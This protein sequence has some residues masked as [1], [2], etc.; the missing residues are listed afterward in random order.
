MRAFA[1]DAYNAAVYLKRSAPQLHVGFL[2]AT[3]EDPLSRAMRDAFAA[4][5]IEDTHAFT[6]KGREP[7]LY[8]IELDASGRAAFP[9]LALGLGRAPLVCTPDAERRR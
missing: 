5:G 1:G 6:A 4:E 8:M 2:T 7:G 3:G 9:L